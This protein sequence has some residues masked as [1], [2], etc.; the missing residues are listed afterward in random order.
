[1]KLILVESPTKS[2][3]LKGFL[4][5]EYEVLATMGHIRDLPKSKIGIDVEKNF[6]PHYI[7][8]IRSKKRVNQLK[9]EAE[10][11]DAVI[12]ATDE[13]REGEAIAYHLI[14]AL[15]LNEEGTAKV[16]RIVFHEITKS[17]IEE[18]LKNPRGVNM[19]LVDAQQ[20][21]RV[22]DR[23]V[24]YKLSPFLWEKVMRRLSAGRVQSVAL[25][26]IA[27]REEEIE[28]F[29]PEEY[30]SIEALLQSRGITRKS[31]RNDPS[32]KLGA[33]A[34][35]KF[36]ALLHKINGEVVPKLGIKTKEEAD[37]IAIDLKQCDFRV[38]KIEKKELKRN[39]LP[40]FTTSTLQQEASRRLRCSAKQTMRFAQSLYENGL[41]TYMRTD[42][43]NLS[44][45]S[46]LAAKSWIEKKLG[47]EYASQAPRFFKTKSRLAQEAHEAIRPTRPDFAPEKFQGENNQEKRLYELIWRRF[48]ASQ[49]PQAIFDSTR[50]EI[51]AKNSLIA[52]YYLLI[53]TGSILKFDGFLKIWPTQFEEKE[54]PA[55]AEKEELK[56]LEVLPSQHFTEPPPRYNEASLIKTLEEYGIGRPSTYAPT[57]SVIQE[58]NYVLKNEDRRFAPTE[59]G[60]AVNKI[61]TEHFPTIVDIQF[62][63]RM[64]EELDEIAIGAEKWQNVIRKFYEPFSVNLEKKYLEV[65]KQKPIEEKTDEDCEKCGKPM[66]IKYGRFGKFM[67]CSGFPDCKNAKPIKN[68]VMDENG[69]K[70]KCPKCAEG[71]VVRKR[72]KRGRF[73]YGCSKYPA[74]DYASWV[75]PQVT[76]NSNAKERKSDEP[77]GEARPL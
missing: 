44:R 58:R 46:V 75:N 39:P 3:T 65:E 43:V 51:E 53:T 10:K 76:E 52:N 62:T 47:K 32:V 4:G 69:V 12:M 15:G 50:V 49:L 30:W 29:K 20:A 66:I 42:S 74:C 61:L 34:E 6:E 68:V 26:L 77:A 38:S 59:I 21:R 2:K 24:G 33:G 57:I 48:I 63:A 40:P 60:C 7:I 13:D 67:A 55:L 18:A 36:T 11:A 17:A 25:R 23:L 14:Q 31:A 54:L 71:E 72:T 22:L 41:I 45:E 16:Q 70:M 8:P 35:N 56:L 19:S 27:E 73:F 37:K 28:N 9:K 5:K 64:E 1:M